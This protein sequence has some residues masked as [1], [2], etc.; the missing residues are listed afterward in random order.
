M[1]G[2]EE[3]RLQNEV[4][5]RIARN[6]ELRQKQ[7]I[8]ALTCGIGTRLARFC[9]VSGNVPDRRI[10]LRNRNPERRPVVVLGHL[11]PRSALAPASSR[12]AVSRRCLKDDR[13]FENEGFSVSSG[14]ATRSGRIAQSHRP[15]SGS[16]GVAVTIHPLFKMTGDMTVRRHIYEAWSS[17]WPLVRSVVAATAVEKQFAVDTE[18][19]RAR[20]KDDDRARFRWS[21][22]AA[23]RHHRRRRRTDHAQVDWRHHHLFD[24]LRA[25]RLDDLRRCSS[26]PFSVSTR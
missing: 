24:D 8:R 21:H 6:E 1:A 13:R 26:L 7:Q 14:R 4:L 3:R 22:A 12:R 15:A 18:S 25:A 20:R 2:L 10:E 16:A 11:C 9:Q 19:P 17:A 23:R 5:R